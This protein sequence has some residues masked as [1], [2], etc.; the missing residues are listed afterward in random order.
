MTVFVNM[1][2]VAIDNIACGTK[3]IRGNGASVYKSLSFALYRNENKFDRI[4]DGCIRVF[5]HILMI[6]YNGI[7]S[8]AQ[9]SKTS[10]NMK[11]S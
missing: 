5:R 1:M 10:I 8:A 9:L 2:Q 3:A 4:I 6:Y 11:F 7:K